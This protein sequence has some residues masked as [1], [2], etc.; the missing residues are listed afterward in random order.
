[1]MDDGLLQ[2]TNL[3]CLAIV[4]AGVGVGARATAVGAAQMGKSGR[5]FLVYCIQRG[6][7]SFRRTTQP[8]PGWLDR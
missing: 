6:V 7:A 1:M 5:A 8:Q 3:A 2:G 4:M